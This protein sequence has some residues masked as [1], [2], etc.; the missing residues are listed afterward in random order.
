MSPPRSTGGN[1]EDNRR[2]FL[3]GSSLLLAGVLPAANA[4]S[5]LETQRA[6]TAANCAQPRILKIGLIGCGR[7][8]LSVTRELLATASAQLSIH[9]TAV[10]DVFP[11]RLQQTLRSLKG[12]FPQ[13][14]SVDAN[15][16]FVGASGFQAL[17]HSDVD[18]VLLT[19][20]PSLRPLHFEAAVAAGKHIY[21]ER[22]IAVDASGI[23][24][25]EAANDCAIRKQLAVSV[26][27]PRRSD[28]R[29]QATLAQ[30][31]QAA[32]G[33]LHSAE[34][35]HWLSPPP[36]QPRHKQTTQ[37]EFQLRNWRNHHSLSGGPWVES[38]L[39]NLDTINW[40]LNSHPTSAHPSMS[41][42]SPSRERG[43]LSH[44]A[45]H[46]TPSR[47]LPHSTTPLNVRTPASTPHFTSSHSPISND[48]FIVEFHYPSGLRLLSGCD[49][50]AS[51]QA[52]RS[53]LTVYGSS[54]HC[55][56]LA[57]KIFDRNGRLTWQASNEHPQPRRDFG[58]LS[59][60]LSAIAS[61]ESFNQGALA[62]E[63]TLTAIL[64]RTVAA[65]GRPISWHDCQMTNDK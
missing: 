38:H 26:G 13:T 52:A 24:R 42:D 61:G 44:L 63:S 34:A 12:Q 5:P 30:L 21:A 27:I 58:Q 40:L 48:T 56:L 6:G 65:D 64:G 8:G 22:P 14:A 41:H 35:Y 50:T 3:R 4:R 17:L 29:F 10:A 9:L 57:G 2:D 54:G 7:R 59:S 16:R 20:P 51:S 47:L 19:A 39:Q 1:H 46:D 43:F 62:V 55:D 32:I 18:L 11:D 25:F 45:S 31:Q 33:P 36:P 23:Q 37:F 15:H 49:T 53:I 28:P 60:L